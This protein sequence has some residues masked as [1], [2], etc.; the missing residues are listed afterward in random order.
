MQGS[1]LNEVLPTYRNTST[2]LV[3]FILLAS[4]CW[5]RDVERVEITSW[6]FPGSYCQVIFFFPAGSRPQTDSIWVL[7]PVLLWGG[8]PNG[9]CSYS[10]SI[11]KSKSSLTLRI[12]DSPLYFS[13]RISYIWK[14][15]P[16]VL[17][18]CTPSIFYRLQ[19][20]ILNLFILV[21]LVMFSLHIKIN[22]SWSF[23]YAFG[24]TSNASY[25][26]LLCMWNQLWL[27][28]SLQKELLRGGYFL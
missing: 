10:W 12:S 21:T 9:W 6:N 27:F 8:A 3:L 7:V 2:D 1:L 16:G 28:S 13:W 15:K 23:C 14:W 5:E 20:R 11:F 19:W 4:V 22:F 25:R 18:G 26:D 24:L 17:G